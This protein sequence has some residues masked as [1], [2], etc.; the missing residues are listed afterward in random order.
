VRGYAENFSW[1]QVA[2]ANKRL[3]EQAAARNLDLAE[4][5][6]LLA[7]RSPDGILSSEV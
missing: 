2:K 4:V 7:P 5:R 3:L 6:A 1:D